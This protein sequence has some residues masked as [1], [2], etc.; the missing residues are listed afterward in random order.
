VESIKQSLNNWSSNQDL[1]KRLEK[2][3]NVIYDNEEVRAF[4]NRHPDVSDE[5]VN[6]SL[7]KLYEFINQSTN[8]E[9]CKSLGECRNIMKGYHPHLFVNGNRIDVRY[10]RCPNKIKADEQRRQ[11]KLFQS[12]YIPKDILK[13]SM[14]N[15]DTSQPERFKAIKA[16]K[17]YIINYL[18][19]TTSKGLFFHGEF[20]VGK[21]YILAALANELAERKSVQ[22][23]MVYT[24]DFFRDMKS[25]I[26]D[27]TVNEKLDYIKKVPLLI[28]D[29]IG[30]ETVTSWVRDDLLGSILQYRMMEQLP[31]LYT[32]N[33]DYTGLENHLTY[34][35]K[36][37]REEELKAKRIM[38]RIRHLTKPV[39]VG[40][41][42]QRSE[43]ND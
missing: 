30:A 13:A 20:G 22:S 12:L 1:K 8:C 36:S 19:E 39:E 27:Q 43:A 42:N 10:E 4:L 7:S 37:D 5:D 17:D 26:Q 32:S 6:R 31:T 18:P 34:T 15:L 25:S 9:S 23:L 41:T 29:D 24:P 2:M 33:Y 40:G 21:T 35:Q 28:L 3:K 38:E 14:D 16:A 11:Q